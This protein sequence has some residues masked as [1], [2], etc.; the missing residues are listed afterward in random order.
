VPC[1]MKKPPTARRR[2]RRPIFIDQMLT[3]LLCAQP[4][5]G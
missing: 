1:P 5:G 3:E 2:R 4:T